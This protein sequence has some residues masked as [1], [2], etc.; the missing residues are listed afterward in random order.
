MKYKSNFFIMIYNF[1]E[2]MVRGTILI[3]IL[4]QMLSKFVDIRFSYF[5]QIGIVTEMIICAIYF[6][7]TGYITVE[8]GEKEVVIKSLVSK[9]KLEFD[10]YFFSS[11]VYIPSTDLFIIHRKRV[12]IAFD[13]NIKKRIKLSNFSKKSFDKVL[14]ILSQKTFD[15]KEINTSLKK[16]IFNIPKKDILEEYV[17]LMKKYAIIAVG[18]VVVLSSG[19]YF[20]IIK[21]SDGR[22]LTPFL[23]IILLLNF[24]ILGVPVI[25]IV[26]GYLVKMNIT[27]ERIEV[28]VDGISIDGKTYNIKEIKQIIVTPPLYKERMI[29]RNFRKII[30]CAPKKKKMLYLGASTV[31]GRVIAIN[32]IVYEEY[33]E[34]CN[35]IGKLAIANDIEFLY[36]ES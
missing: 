32:K 15:E 27:P 10:K 11:K 29:G 24:L 14:S 17:K 25:I 9:K 22:G 1:V 21:N 2:I 6:I 4:I 33:G 20:L 28:D 13:G 34:L 19:L 8:I 36:D 23:G 12:L 35:A 31:A 26:C 3:F 30:I 16:E 5:Y 7:T 18:A